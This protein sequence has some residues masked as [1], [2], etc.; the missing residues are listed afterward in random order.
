MNWFQPKKSTPCW[1]KFKFVQTM[2]PFF[3]LRG[4]K[5]KNTAQILNI[6]RTTRSVKQ[7]L[8]ETIRR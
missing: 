2:G 1:K 6:S 7:N 5:A 8:E 4:K 3:F